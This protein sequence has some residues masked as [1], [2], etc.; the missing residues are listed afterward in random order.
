MPV[1]GIRGQSFPKRRDRLIALAQLF[2]NFA[3]RKPGGNKARREIGGLQEQIGGG[4]EIAFQ[5]QIAGKFEPP[6]GNQIAGGQEQAR[7][8][9]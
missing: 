6:V 8:H 1:L 5:L 7:G 3:E 4:G 2:A 9:F